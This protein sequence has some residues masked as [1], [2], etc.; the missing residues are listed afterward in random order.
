MKI[1]LSAGSSFVVSHMCYN[2]T[3]VITTDNSGFLKLN[4]IIIGIYL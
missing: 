4:N 3:V 1:R 2:V